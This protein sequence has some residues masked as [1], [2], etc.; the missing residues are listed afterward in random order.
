[1]KIASTVNED[2]RERGEG[3]GGGR[4]RRG[5]K[6]SRVKGKV[7]E[8]TFRENSLGHQNREASCRQVGLN[9]LIICKLYTLIILIKQ[10][11]FGICHNIITM[12]HYIYNILH[13]RQD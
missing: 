8:V 4:I 1:M 2:E 6:S 12:M 10:V 5:A 11:K 7:A 13:S 9:L 3:A